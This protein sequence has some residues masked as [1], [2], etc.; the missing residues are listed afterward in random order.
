[1]TFVIIPFPDN[2]Q[3]RAACFLISFPLSGQTHCHIFF[4]YF[5]SRLQ[6]KFFIF[7]GR[8]YNGELLVDGVQGLGHGQRDS[9]SGNVCP[10]GDICSLSPF[11]CSTYPQTRPWLWTPSQSG[12]ESMS[13]HLFHKVL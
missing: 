8:G 11:S 4:F 10:C 2:Y 9:W 13:C 7:R 6:Q 12:T 1:M 3:Q 5:R